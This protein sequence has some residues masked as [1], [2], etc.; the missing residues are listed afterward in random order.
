MELN[1]EQIKLKEKVLRKISET[2]KDSNFKIPI[3]QEKGQ[4]GNLTNITKN[5]YNMGLLK[6]W[7]EKSQ[8]AFPTVFKVTLEGTEKWLEEQVMKRED[9]I[10]FM[11]ENNKRIYEGHLGFSNFNYIDKSC[12]ID[13]VIRGIEG[14][15]G[16]MTSAHYAITSWGFF[17]LGMRRITLRVFSDLERAVSLYSRAGFKK[18]KDIPMKKTVDGD[19]ITFEEAG[20]DDEIA[21]LFTVMELTSPY[22]EIKK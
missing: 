7:R 1:E 21:R 14:T 9:R 17:D 10:L 19:K 20:N 8:Y 6:E 11:I 3:Y 12:E 16:I 22:E 13:N 5:D 18:V 2:K 4:I 15:K